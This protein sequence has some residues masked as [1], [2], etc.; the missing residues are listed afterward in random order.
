MG[1]PSPVLVG[2]I[3]GTKA[4]LA[5]VERDGARWSVPR[6]RRYEIA[7]HP[8][9]LWIVRDFLG[10]DKSP[11]TACF[12]FAGR[13]RGRRVEG[14]NLSWSVDADVLERE[15]GL[16]QVSLVND[17]VAAA[18]GAVLLGPEDLE[19][20]QQGEEDP[21]GH[22]AVLGA[23]T[24]LGEAILIRRGDGFDVMPTE[25]GHA[26]FAPTDDLQIDL[27]RQLRRDLGRV[28]LDRVVSGP[29]LV[30]I[31]EFLRVRGAAPESPGVRKKMDEGD[32]A[33]AIGV[34]AMTSF[35]PLSTRAVE[36]FVSIYGAEAG[37]LAL[38]SL[39]TGGIYVAGGIAPR[40]APAMCSDAFREAF[41]NK[42]RY[43][44][45]MER[46]PIRLVTNLDAPL[47]GAAALA[48]GHP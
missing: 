13:V 36:V 32:P 29:G 1:D 42:G 24:G 27:L 48:A 33:A 9:M 26:S 20:I 23:G 31:Y 17:F 22:R 6:K 44:S 39:A 38:R 7:R 18:R 30:R 46:N 8:G 47:L 15:L 35:D 28:S 21:D 11:A 12:G 40:V 3:G 45:F 16:R 43:A 37:D 10:D 41:R 34:A 19:V 4:L 25:G 14:T 2:D 5:I